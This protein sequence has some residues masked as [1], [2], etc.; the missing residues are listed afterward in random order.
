MPLK[1]CR[2]RF[3]KI[4]PRSQHPA[5]P[6]GIPCPR[7][8][9]RAGGSVGWNVSKTAHTTEGR[10][11]LCADSSVCPCWAPGPFLCWN[12]TGM[13][14]SRAEFRPWALELLSKHS[15]S[16]HAQQTQIRPLL[17]HLVLH[18]CYCFMW[19]LISKSPLSSKWAQSQHTAHHIHI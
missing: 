13:N 18:Q 6:W 15:F 1:Y 17:P 11:P 5:E 4:L 9:C 7:K 14:F 2:S 10:V 16:W 8:L 19:S 3:C 12:G